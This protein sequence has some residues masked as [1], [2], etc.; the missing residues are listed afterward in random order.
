MWRILQA[1]EP[2][3]FVIATG[4]MHSVREFLEVAAAHVDL[5]WEEV[6]E[7]DERYLR[8]AEVDALCGDPSKAAEKLDWR[9]TVT[10]EE[11]VRIMVDADVKELDD[12]LAGRAV[13]RS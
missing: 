8:P 12:Q 5:D 6:V 3:D 11:L 7:F 10:F 1:D 9:P 4:E 13:R 2:D